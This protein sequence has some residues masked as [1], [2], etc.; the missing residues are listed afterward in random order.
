M[1]RCI[2]VAFAAFA[3]VP[4]LAQTYRAVPVETLGGSASAVWGI[5]DNGIVVGAGETG[6]GAIHAAAWIEGKAINLGGLPGGDSSRAFSINNADQITG[7]AHNEQ[8]EVRPVRWDRA[9]PTL[10]TITDLGTLG[11]NTG[12]G[13]HIN[14][15][16]VIVGRSDLS[17]GR[18]HAFS[19]EVGAPPIDLGIMSYP[20]SRGYS[21][22]LG[23]NDAGVIVGY[24]YAT[25]FG[26]DHAMLIDAEGV[27]DITPPGQFTF[28]RAHAVNSS[29]T[30]AGIL[31]L[32][33]GQSDGFEA[34]VYTTADGWIELG[35]VSGL[36]ESEAYDIN[37]AGDVVGVS[38]DLSTQIYKGFIARDGKVVELDTVVTNAPGT[39]T[40]AHEINAGGEIAANAVNAFGNSVGIML[41]P[42]EACA[43]DWNNSGTVD[44]Q[45]FFDFLTVFFSG[46]ADFNHDEVTNSQDFF[47]F[48]AAFFAGCEN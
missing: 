17:T 36:A 20:Q 23:I 35:V 5:N 11:G 7:W 12:W 14:A 9:S 26:P 28:A 21:E 32:P 43:A 45:D 48:L 22:A 2:P 44:S 37:D 25:L 1:I 13:N 30:V 19:A 40:D 31:T 16:G 29:K 41:I 34:A 3:A 18:Y 46:V 8:G 47:D 10:W 15:S 27:H 33:G 24:A 4:A 6:T 39:I 42:D 38:Y